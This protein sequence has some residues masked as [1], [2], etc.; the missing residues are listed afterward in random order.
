MQA[1]EFQLKRDVEGW[2]KTK[3][4]DVESMRTGIMGYKGEVHYH[5]APC[6]DEWLDTLPE[7]LPKGELFDVIAAHI[8][9]EIHRHYRLYASNRVAAGAESTAEERAALVNRTEDNA[10]V[11]LI[12]SDEMKDASI[13]FSSNNAR[14]CESTA[15]AKILPDPPIFELPKTNN[16]GRWKPLYIY[17]KGHKYS[18]WWSRTRSVDYPHEQRRVMDEGK[19]GR[20]S[21]GNS[22]LGVRPTVYV[23]LG[24]LNIGSGNGS[25]DNPYQLL[26]TGG[27]Y[28]A[29][30]PAV[31]EE[32]VVEEVPVE[33]EPVEEYTEPQQGGGIPIVDFSDEENLTDDPD[34]VPA[35]SIPEVDDSYYYTGEDTDDGQDETSAK[36][37][38]IPLYVEDRGTRRRS[39]L[40]RYG[41][42]KQP[43]RTLSRPDRPGLPAGGAERVRIRE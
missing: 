8:D 14:L 18:P 31:Q 28:V 7:D 39:G 34:M 20:I 42:S 2:R 22:D 25:M 15:Y 6:I 4:D 33:Q 1:R 35:G 27:A 5:C 10:L 30:V 24:L 40:Y 3:Q 41:G 38:G 19:I 36:G 17:S 21:T 16:K 43:E 23:N 11:T 26:P 9:S 29:P 12:T 13:G 37:G 32:P